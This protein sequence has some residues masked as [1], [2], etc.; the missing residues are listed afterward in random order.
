MMRHI[1]FLL[2]I[3]AMLI[4]ATGCTA[5][6]SGLSNGQDTLPAPTPT[7]TIV[8]ATTPTAIIDPGHV[9]FITQDNTPIDGVQILPQSVSTSSGNNNQ[10]VIYS[11]KMDFQYNE[12][13]MVVDVPHPPL[14]IDLDITPELRTR[15]KEGTSDYGEKKDY[16]YQIDHLS[17]NVW[18]ECTVKDAETDTIVVKDGF[19][20]TFALDSTREI[21]IRRSG[22]YQITFVGNFV[23]AEIMMRIPERVQQ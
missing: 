12:I 1:G 2:I 8:P 22:T 16:R 5:P 17:Q 15:I 4:V 11:Q 6:P 18:L 20:R 13:T 23:T 7:A 9:T 14:I 21:V 10:T 3:C 19:G